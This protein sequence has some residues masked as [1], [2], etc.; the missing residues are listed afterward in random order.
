MAKEKRISVASKYRKRSRFGEFWYRFKQNKGAVV[1]LVVTLIIVFLAIF[2]DVLFD[3]KTDIASY[4]MK[5]ALIKPCAAHPFGTDNLGRDLFKR[6][7]YG[8][9]YSMLIGVS[10][11]ILGLVFGIFF[12]ATAGFFGGTYD[13]LIMRFFDIL[14]AIPSLLLGIVIVSV[15]GQNMTVLI[16]A[17]GIP[18]I[19]GIVNITRASVMTVRSQ[20]FVESA[21]AIGSKEGRII[22]KHILPNCLSPIIV[23]MTLGV[24]GCIISASSL[25]Y[26]GLGVP[27]PTPEWGAL[28]SAGKKYIQQHGYMCLFPGLAIMI[29]VLALNMVGDG[30]RDALDPKL[31]K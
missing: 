17:I 29:T 23:R 18:H 15:F 1:G 26:L 30:L 14:R 13:L 25:S 21:R 5:E 10:S 31:K 28:L 24:A 27:V 12:G 22:A 19:S 16:I 20:E 4:N 8:T 7:L 6:V 3:Y 2:S 11:I 9:R